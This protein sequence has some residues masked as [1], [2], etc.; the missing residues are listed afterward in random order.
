VTEKPIW[1]AESEYRCGEQVLFGNFINGVVEE[2]IFCR[3]M[4]QPNYLVEYWHNGEL[5][6]ARLHEADLRPMGGGN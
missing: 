1:T 5:L 4:T 3:H 2:V 6:A